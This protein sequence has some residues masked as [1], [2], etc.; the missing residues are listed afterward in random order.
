[1]SIKRGYLQI[2]HEQPH[3][4]VVESSRSTAGS[5]RCPAVRIHDNATYR[6]GKLVRSYKDSRSTLP[7]TDA[8]VS[9]IA[10]AELSGL[11]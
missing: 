2:G 1:V 11:K 5:A 9:K 4:D 7:P 3:N 6:P 10:H 8:M